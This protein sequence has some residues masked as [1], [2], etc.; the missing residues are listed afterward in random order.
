MWLYNQ[1]LFTGLSLSHSLSVS[2]MVCT[3]G[4]YLG[5]W[6]LLIFVRFF[7]FFFLSLLFLCSVPVVFLTV[8]SRLLI[9]LLLVVVLRYFLVVHTLRLVLHALFSYCRSLSSQNISPLMPCRSA[10]RFSTSLQLTVDFIS[11][12]TNT[13]LQ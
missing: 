12:K 8:P 7:F 1:S 6:F 2:Q 13:R 3:A 5:L 11:L 9:C 10:R 4:L